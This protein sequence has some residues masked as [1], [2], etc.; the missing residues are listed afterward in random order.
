MILLVRDKFERVWW[1][2]K[3]RYDSNIGVLVSLLYNWKIGRS[4][5]DYRID[6]SEFWN[7]IWKWFDWQIGNFN[8]DNNL[9]MFEFGYTYCRKRVLLDFF[10]DIKINV[11]TLYCN[12]CSDIVNMWRFVWNSSVMNIDQIQKVKYKSSRSKSVTRV[13]FNF[14]L[15]RICFSSIQSKNALKKYIFI[16]IFFFLLLFKPI[17]KSVK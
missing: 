6:E 4:S 15:K 10:Y 9:L 13:F 5:I 7:G 2:L 16:Y 11:V 12:L 3:K 1:N 8:K 17:K 14:Q